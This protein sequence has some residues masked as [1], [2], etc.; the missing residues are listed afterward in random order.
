MDVILQSCLSIGREAWQ[1]LLDDVLCLYLLMALELTKPA[2][3]VVQKRVQLGG[4][5]EVCIVKLQRVCARMNVL[6]LASE[7]TKGICT[8]ERV[9]TS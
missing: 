1:Q 6:K 8:H 7:A 2:E 9:R 3:E 4:I 5:G